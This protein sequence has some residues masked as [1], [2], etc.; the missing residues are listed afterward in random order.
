MPEENKSGSIQMPPTINFKDTIRIFNLML[1]LLRVYHSCVGCI[2]VAGRKEN[3]SR[4]WL[5]C[6]FPWLWYLFVQKP[7]VCLSQWD[8]QSVQC[9]S[10]CCCVLS[11]GNHLLKRGPRG[12]RDRLEH[13]PAPKQDAQLESDLAARP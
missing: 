8:V 7:F 3:S 11:A 4:L 1:M 5:M 13:F 10:C 2:L 12:K 9:N 6:T